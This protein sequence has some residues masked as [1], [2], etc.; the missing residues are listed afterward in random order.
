MWVNGGSIV[1]AHLEVAGS[2][3]PSSNNRRIGNQRNGVE[4]TSCEVRADWAENNEAFGEFWW[5]KWIIGYYEFIRS[6]IWLT[7]TPRVGSV[8]I[9]V[10]RM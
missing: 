3:V 4:T 9:I 8:P 10:G 7:E 2:A 1:G 5:L 6:K